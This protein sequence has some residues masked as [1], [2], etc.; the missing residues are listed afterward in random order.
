MLATLRNL[1]VKP[2]ENAAESEATAAKRLEIASAALLFEV[3]KADHEPDAREL[4]AISDALLGSGSGT[5]RDVE[6]LL[7][8]AS[9]ES[10]SAT[11][12]YEFT[13]L[14]NEHCGYAEKT[15]L[16]RNMWRIA[17]ADSRLDKYEDYV[18][19]K[20]CDLIHVSHG[21]FILAKLAEKKRRESAAS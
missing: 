2:P 11:S 4:A 6:E 15:G 10:D 7:A 21:D 3:L 13:S 20:V 1:L 16:I 19:R 9:S 5:E 18:I 17:W 12:L 14:I 8:L